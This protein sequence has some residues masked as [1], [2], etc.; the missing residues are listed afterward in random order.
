MGP[1]AD[2]HGTAVSRI[3]QGIEMA[4]TIDLRPRNELPIDVPS[5]QTQEVAFHNPPGK[6]RSHRLQI[7]RSRLPTI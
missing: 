5:Y 3:V 1:A 7:V 6:P 4:L 2:L